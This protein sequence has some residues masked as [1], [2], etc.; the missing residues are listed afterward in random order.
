MTLVGVTVSLSSLGQAEKYPTSASSHSGFASVKASVSS[1]IGSDSSSESVRMTLGPSG[2]VMLEAREIKEEKPLVDAAVAPGSKSTQSGSHAVAL[3]HS[4][5][6]NQSEEKSRKQPKVREASD[7]E[8]ESMR[9]FHPSPHEYDLDDLSIDVLRRAV[10]ASA[11]AAASSGS[12]A[13]IS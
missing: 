13:T 6:K 3:Q 8:M 11:E 1:D 4:F 10:V 12:A 7:V 5:L 9:S 2:A